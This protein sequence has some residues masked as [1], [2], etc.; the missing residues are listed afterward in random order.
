MVVVCNDHVESDREDGCDDED[1]K[2]EVVQGAYEER[3][4]GLG[5]EGFSVIVSKLLSS[6]YEVIAIK[7]DL[8]I[9]LQ[10]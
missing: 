4:P 10:L 3:D 9:D 2:H 6:L 7:T 1:L 5:L 8:N